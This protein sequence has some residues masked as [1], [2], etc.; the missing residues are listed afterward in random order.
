MPSTQLSL[1]SEKP[2]DTG[3]VSKQPSPAVA[4]STDPN[5]PQQQRAMRLRGGCFVSHSS[6]VP[7]PI[8]HTFSRNARYPAGAVTY[9]SVV[10]GGKR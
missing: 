8:T 1:S 5:A 7:M 6:A 2:N 3:P 9:H 10:E 4:M